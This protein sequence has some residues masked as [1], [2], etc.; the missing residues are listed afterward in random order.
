MP[1]LQELSQ[2]FAYE[3]GIIQVI[4]ENWLDANS[5]MPVYEIIRELT[6]RVGLRIPGPLEYLE[7][8]D[9]LYKAAIL[10]WD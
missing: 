9:V 1:N 2:R 8:L 4:F 10:K 3:T 7:Y 5:N 6:G